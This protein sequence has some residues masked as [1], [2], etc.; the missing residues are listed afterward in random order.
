MISYISLR[1]Q[2]DRT[3]FSEMNFIGSILE[4]GDP[5]RII[6]AFAV[7]G[8]LAFIYQKK[9][10]DK[11]SP[12]ASWQKVPGAL[13]V[14]GNPIPGGMDNLN[15]TLEDWAAK[16]G[17]E[18]GVYE[19]NIFGTRTIVV[20][21]QEKLTLLD[22]YRS[23]FKL[24]RTEGI[25]KGIDSVGAD[26][27]FSAE[28]QIWKKDRRMVG[29]FLNRQ[30]IIDYVPSIKLVGSRLCDKWEALM[31]KNGVVTIN[32]DILSA[33]MDIVSLISCGQDLDSIT[34][35]KVQLGE[36]IRGIV[37]KVVLR[38]LVPFSFWNIPFIGQ[39]L[40]GGGWYVKRVR[41]KL[42]RI[43]DDNKKS[44]SANDSKSGTKL[45]FLSKLLIQSQDEKSHLDIDRL[46]GNL[47]TFF[48]AGTDTT[49]N[50]LSV[51]LYML[52]A[53]KVLQDKIVSELDKNGKVDF[54]HLQ[55]QS[56][57]TMSFIYEVLRFYGPSPLL[58]F[59]NPKPID[60]D[61]TELPAK[62]QI[63]ILNG[64]A[65]TS[66]F[67]KNTDQSTPRGYKDSPPSTF[68]AERY[69][70]LGSPSEESKDSQEVPSLHPTNPKAG[71]RA[72]G[73][74]IRVCPGQQFAE[75]ELILLIGCIL[76]KFELGLKEGH[77]P[78]K[79]VYKFTRCPGSD[80]QLTLKPRSWD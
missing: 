47:L 39:Y 18:T 13:P 78:L 38:S 30:H 49:T 8:I 23:S 72:F 52:A 3:T 17:K 22:K 60:L 16:Y 66:D 77:P 68:D 34:K 57:R 10:S 41:R 46:F 25:R 40:D 2:N 35:G 36:D 80:I 51:C 63:M 31:A 9:R 70:I 20:C 43:V 11:R 21:N 76:R 5:H 4:S 15:N 61:G 33:T 6:F 32:E 27:L 55:E 1:K 44:L 65:M 71:Y 48:I 59:E 50:T 79:M 12:E 73:S 62:T 58:F 67:E 19:Y 26:G 54:Q 74:S 29:P 69:L 37:S 75:S 53:D 64:Y 45:S 14:I 24:Q 28:G 7:G 42:I 56:P